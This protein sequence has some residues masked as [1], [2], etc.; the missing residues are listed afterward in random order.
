MFFSINT[1][2]PNYICD[3]YDTLSMWGLARIFQEAADRHAAS[4][5]IGFEQLI[6]DNKA[7]VLCRVYYKIHRLPKEGE[8]V[9]AKTWSRGNDGLFAF[10]DYSLSDNQGTIIASST[11]YWVIIDLQQRKAI[12]LHDMMS[13]FEYHNEQATDRSTLDRVRIPKIEVQPQPVSQFAVKPSMLDHNNHVN[14]A[15]YIKWIFDN[16]QPTTLKDIHHNFSFTIEYF[17]ETPP[18]DIISVFRIPTDNATYFKISNSH[19]VAVT[20]MIE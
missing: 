5:G 4:G 13:D 18:N 20:A 8:E 16:L 17:Q 2:I 3:Q 15:E 6:Q 11:S 10:R 9:T 1:V 19:S 14:N 7:W 12:R